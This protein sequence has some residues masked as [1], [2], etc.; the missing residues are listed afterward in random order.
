MINSWAVTI[1][2]IGME[3]VD[4]ARFSGLGAFISI[5]RNFVILSRRELSSTVAVS[6]CCE[7]SFFGVPVGVPHGSGS[8]AIPQSGSSADDSDISSMDKQV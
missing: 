3:H 4:F 2:T 6:S 1:S 7:L 8:R 5:C